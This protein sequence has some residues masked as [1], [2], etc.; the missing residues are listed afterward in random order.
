VLARSRH[1]LLGNGEKLDY[2]SLDLWQFDENGKIV[3]CDAYYNSQGYL[4]ADQA[5]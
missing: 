5:D 2:L 4:S 1:W 3:R